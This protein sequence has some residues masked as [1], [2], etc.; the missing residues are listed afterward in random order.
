[1]NPNIIKKQLELTQSIAV[2]DVNRVKTL[3]EQIKPHP[4][5][6]YNLHLAAHMGDIDVVR[7]L[8]QDGRVDPDQKWRG[9]LACD[10]RICRSKTIQE[11]IRQH[12][13]CVRWNNKT[14]RFVI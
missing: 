11:Y 5:P 14:Y 10:R 8:V 9:M 3:I 1:M 2:G 13:S 4:I 12:Q 6:L 7:L